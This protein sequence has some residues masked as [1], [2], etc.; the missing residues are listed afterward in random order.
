MPNYPLS[1][2]GYNN[3]IL[4]VL[5]HI[6]LKADSN[7]DIV[8]IRQVQYWHFAMTRNLN[9][10]LWS[11]CLRIFSFRVKGL[12]LDTTKYDEHP[13]FLSRNGQGQRYCQPSRCWA[14]TSRHYYLMTPKWP[15]SLHKGF[16]YW[17]SN[18][19]SRKQTTREKV[20]QMCFKD[21]HVFVTK[22]GKK[23]VK[24]C[25]IMMLQ[26][27]NRH[28]N[29]I[30]YTVMIDQL[31][32]NAMPVQAT[33]QQCG[34][35][36]ALHVMWWHFWQTPNKIPKLFMS[37]ASSLSNQVSKTFVRVTLSTLNQL[38]VHNA[39][40]TSKHLGMCKTHRDISKG[41]NDSAFFKPF[42]LQLLTFKLLYLLKQHQMIDIY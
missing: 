20:P 21:T 7:R 39:L 41:R 40:K 33:Y 18:N 24:W 38:R 26:L 8:I 30:T 10:P 17:Q 2:L 34:M 12:G 23:S 13:L 19:F 28:C 25:T 31:V 9:K 6:F 37:S 16:Q 35:N 36:P 15:Y 3:Y 29:D 32:E 4:L 22:V 42:E 11:A 14:N 1:I 5:D 27:L